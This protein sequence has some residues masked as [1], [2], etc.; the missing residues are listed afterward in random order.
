M[1]G[2]TA[3]KPGAPRSARPRPSG[4]PILCAGQGQEIGTQGADIAR[5]PSRAPGPRRHAGGRPPRGRV[6]PPRETGWMTPVSLLA[7]MI[8]T[9]AAAP[10]RSQAPFERRKVDL[11]LRGHRQVARRFAAEIDRR[12]APRDARCADSRLEVA[13]TARARGHERQHVGLGAAG[14]EDHVARA[15]RRPARRPVR[16]PARSAGARRGP[17]RGPRTG[18]H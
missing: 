13:S 6:A 16:A 18:C 2:S 17:R 12:R 8:E 9:S 7:S 15:R 4:P 10:E 5:N 11:T 1:S 14:G 3:C